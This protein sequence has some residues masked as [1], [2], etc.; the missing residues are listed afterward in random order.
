MNKRKKFEWYDHSTRI[1]SGICSVVL[2][3]V[4]IIWAI[5]SYQLEKLHCCLPGT[6]RYVNS[7]VVFL[8][9]GQFLQSFCRS[10]S[11][12]K[13]YH[14]WRSHKWYSQNLVKSQSGHAEKSLE[15]VFHH[16]NFFFF[17]ILK[18]KLVNSEIGHT[19]KS[20]AGH[21]WSTKGFSS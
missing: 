9:W 6:I 19:E 13:S 11:A 5:N 8:G 18:K 1:L 20:F 12:Y 14:K 21:M 2:A 7:N 10:I 15:R 4:N 17:S 16:Y 3:R